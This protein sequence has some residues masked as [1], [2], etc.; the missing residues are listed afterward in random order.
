MRTHRWSGVPVE[1]LENLERWRSAMAARPACQRGVEVPFKL[2]NVLDD[3]E[4][5]EEF[6][7][8]ARATVQR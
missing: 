7:K 5:T 4:A 6:A 1:G 2:P 3:E 8:G